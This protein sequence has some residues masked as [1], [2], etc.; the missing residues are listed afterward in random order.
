MGKGKGFGRYWRIKM[1]L[2]RNYE[3]LFARRTEGNR[4]RPASSTV[5][6][7]SVADVSLDAPA[8]FGGAWGESLRDDSWSN[9]LEEMGA[10][11]W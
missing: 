6:I 11:V 4:V 5:R 7:V 2:P 3:P 8:P 10:T 9:W 1:G